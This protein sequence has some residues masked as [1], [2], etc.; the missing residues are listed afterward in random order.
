[1]KTIILWE[2]IDGL[3]FKNKKDAET[4]E[5]SSLGLTLDEYKQLNELEK[6]EKIAS[7]NLS[8]EQNEKT[9]EDYTNAIQAVINFRENHNLPVDEHL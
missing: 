2:T 8:Y 5:A 4:H 9:L 7:H 3:Q 1:M 6:R